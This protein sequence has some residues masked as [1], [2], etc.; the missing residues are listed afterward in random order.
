MLLSFFHL[1][2]RDVFQTVFL[3]SQREHYI[4]IMIIIIIWIVLRMTW[5]V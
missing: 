1:E 2:L 4:M 3:A 5:K